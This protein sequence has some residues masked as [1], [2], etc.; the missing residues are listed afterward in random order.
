LHNRV[1]APDEPDETDAGSLLGQLRAGRDKAKLSAEAVK[2]GAS[3]LRSLERGG[4]ELAAE[5]AEAPVW[6]ALGSADVL[7]AVRRRS[8]AGARGAAG[9]RSR[10]CPTNPSFSCSGAPP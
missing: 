1:V 9:P 10:R 7:I 5:F 4:L 3:A 2:Q 8:R 6:S